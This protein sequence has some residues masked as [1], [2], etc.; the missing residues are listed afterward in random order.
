MVLH[1]RVVHR[2]RGVSVFI[3]GRLAFDRLILIKAK[4][5]VLK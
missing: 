3:K 5:K 2:N 1:H 4:S